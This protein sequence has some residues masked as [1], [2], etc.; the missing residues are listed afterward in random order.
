MR[1]LEPQLKSILD[2]AGLL[3]PARRSYHKLAR[4]ADPA[5]IALRLG[6]YTL[7]RT[8]R[9]P[10]SYRPPLMWVNPKDIKL[11]LT[12]I[13]WLGGFKYA[14]KGFILRGDWDL[15]LPT[16]AT[17]SASVNMRTVR[18]LFVEGV[19][20][21]QCTQYLRMKQRLEGGQ[22]LHDLRGCKTVEDLDR[23]FERLIGAYESIRDEGYKT[24]RELGLTD[25]HEMEL[26]I[27]RNGIPIKGSRANHRIEICRILGV[28]AM[29]AKVLGVHYLWARSCVQQYGDDV[30]SAVEQGLRALDARPKETT[31]VA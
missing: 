16:P 27:D 26:F 21:H 13:E 23:Y 15:R 10:T 7:P 31:D 20:V 3:E 8:Y 12:G 30:R 28:K 11:R 1:V 19:P 5:A 6:Y 18:E 17:A 9:L 25:E 22:R 29:P 4:S 24:Q 2:H 14:R